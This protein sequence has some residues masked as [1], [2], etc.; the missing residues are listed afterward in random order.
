MYYTVGLILPVRVRMERV[1]EEGKSE[2]RSTDKWMREYLPAYITAQP[3]TIYRT[4]PRFFLP[5]YTY[6]YIYI[7]IYTW[8]CQC[9]WRWVY[10]VDPNYVVGWHTASSLCLPT[11]SEAKTNRALHEVSLL[12]F[13]LGLDVSI[14]I[15]P[16]TLRPLYI[17]RDPYQFQ[18]S[19]D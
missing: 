12:I 19:I 5:R 11:Q 6:M 3:R 4:H 13:L 10:R 9:M 16:S 14:R 2:T 7:C 15:H 1:G 18:K 8:V 17:I